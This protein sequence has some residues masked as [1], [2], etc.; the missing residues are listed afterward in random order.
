M[1]FILYFLFYVDVLS[2]SA[3]TLLVRRHEERPACKKIEWWG[4][5]IV[6][7]L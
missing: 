6:I 5:D 1:L 4:T 3:L 2:F 7:C